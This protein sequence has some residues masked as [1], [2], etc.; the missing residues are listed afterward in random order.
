MSGKPLSRQPL[1]RTRPKL[2]CPAC[3]SM[4]DLPATDC[5]ECG[6]DLRTG[7]LP[8]NEQL[9]FFLKHLKTGAKVAAFLLVVLVF[10]N[11]FLKYRFETRQAEHQSRADSRPRMLALE[12]TPEAVKR[13]A[14]E[15]PVLARPYVRV[16]EAR[17]AVIKYNQT[18]GKQQKA[19]DEL[20]K[21]AFGDPSSKHKRED[22]P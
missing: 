11:G 7:A 15:H 9:E 13:L 14:K 20:E 17:S 4:V 8:K 6:A 10:Y 16:I 19:L 12:E 18:M 22:Q 3:G 21:S 5:S 1:T 2:R